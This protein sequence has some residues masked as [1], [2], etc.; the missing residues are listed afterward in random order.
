MQQ[1]NW[2]L[3]FR[4][5]DAASAARCLASVRKVLPSQVVEAPKPY[6]KLPELWEV[7]LRSPLAAPIAEGVLDLLL[8][9]NRLANGWL[10][11][12][13]TLEHGIVTAF[14]GIFDAKSSRSHVAGL[15][16]ASF[17]VGD[18]AGGWRA[19]SDGEDR[20][21][22]AQLRTRFPLLSGSL[23][24][25]PHLVWDVS[26]IYDNR[27]SFD[28]LETDLNLQALVALRQ[29]TKPGEELYAID[30]QHDW[31]RFQP[32][33]MSMN[34]GKDS[35]QIPILPDGDAYFFFPED[36]RFGI[37]AIPHG[38]IC[39]YGADLLQAFAEHPPAIFQ[40]QIAWPRDPWPKGETTW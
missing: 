7:T 5:N 11:S 34:S 36:F 35:W 37:I 31:Y 19:L 10:V 29:C 27:E 22:E 30:W 15:A 39:L 4:V 12:G 3:M 28:D 1:V 23:P 40:K 17:S 8:T 14:S 21:L 25:E 32:H 24:P 16:W 2:R 38:T 13:P 26:A 18:F 9:A 33:A 20:S 6:W